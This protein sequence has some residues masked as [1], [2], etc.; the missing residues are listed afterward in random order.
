MKEP[1]NHGNRKMQ[2]PQEKI[3]AVVPACNE[4]RHIR[5]VVEG[6]RVHLE[7]VIVIDDGSNDDT[8]EKAASA[9]A[10]VIRHDKNQGKGMALQHGFDRARERGF[11]LIVCL[12]GDRQH[13]PEAI[14]DFIETY[15]RTGIPVLVGNRMTD[16]GCMPF[17]RRVTN[18]FMSWILCRYMKQYVPDTQCGYRLYR[19]DV[20]PFVAASSS[21]FAAESEILL[22]IAER[23]IR[24]GNVRVKTIYGDEQSKVS[25]LRDTVR[26]IRMIN[27]YR[28]TRRRRG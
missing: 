6:A 3:A 14:P 8:A 27:H 24:I 25:P 22:H 13:D 21:R 23:G 15:Q 2:I 12:D 1:D 19:T 20:L 9:G 26:F 11:A 17:V 28:A 4:G 10:E 16:L 18:R 7:N 5:Q